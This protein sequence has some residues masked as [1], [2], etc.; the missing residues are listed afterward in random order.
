MFSHLAITTV[1]AQVEPGHEV[2]VF[3]CGSTTG[4]GP[5]SATY[6]PTLRVFGMTLGNSNSGGVFYFQRAGTLGQWVSI[7]INVPVNGTY[8]V[9]IITRNNN[10]RGSVQNYIGRNPI[11]T[12]TTSEYR[13]GNAIGSPMN[14]QAAGAPAANAA[15]RNWPLAAGTPNVVQLVAASVFLEQ[16]INT[17]QSVVTTAGDV[18]IVGLYITLIEEENASSDY[19]SL[20]PDVVELDITLNPTINVTATVEPGWSIVRWRLDDESVA[21]ISGTGSTVGITAKS[22]GRTRLFVTVTNGATEETTA[23]N[24]IVTDTPAVVVTPGSLR[25]DATTNPNATLTAAVAEGWGNIQWSSSNP[26]IASVNPV[27]GS[28]SVTVTGL[29]TGTVNIIATVSNG[30]QTSTSVTGVVVEVT[31]PIVLNRNS[32]R[33]NIKAPVPTAQVVASP[34]SGY[35]IQSWSSQESGIATVTPEANLNIAIIRA[36]APGSTTLTVTAVR[37]A[38]NDIK[39]LEFGVVVTDQ[40][41]VYI[42]YTSGNPSILAVNAVEKTIT[43]ANGTTA[44]QL[45]DAGIITAIPGAAAITNVS[46]AGKTG[47]AAVVDGDTLAVTQGSDTGVYGIVVMGDASS[48]DIRANAWVSDEYHFEFHGSNIASINH[49]DCEIVLIDG[50]TRYF[51]IAEIVSNFGSGSVDRAMSDAAN[52]TTYTGSVGRHRSLRSASNT[53]TQFESLNGTNQTYQIQT[54][55]GAV[56]TTAM[57]VTGDKLVVTAQDG[58]TKREYSIV[59][60]QAALSGKLY[61]ESG[62]STVGTTQDLILTYHAGQRTPE[63]EVVIELPPGV[64]ADYTNT[65]VNI[66]GRGEVRLDKFHLSR[67]KEIGGV[68][69]NQEM[70]KLLGRFSVNYPYQTLGTVNIDGNAATGKTITFNMLDLRPNNGED[71]ILRIEGN[72]VN[73]NYAGERNFSAR[74]KTLD[75]S[76]TPST[77]A[78]SSL[79]QAS[80]STVLN[81]VHNVSSLKREIYDDVNFAARSAIHEGYRNKTI[82]PGSNLA[83]LY[84]LRD[85]QYTEGVRAGD[86]TGF[87]MYWIPPT[88]ATSVTIQRATGT[89]S[90]SGVTLNNDWTDFATVSV[91]ADSYKITGLPA[92]VYNRFRINV[93]GGSNPGPSNEVGFYSGRLS[94]GTLGLTGTTAAAALTNTA[95]INDAI[96]WLSSIDG[97]TLRF[98]SG[99]SVRTGTIRL[100]SNV[101]LYVDS[102]AYLHSIVGA[103]DDPEPGWWCYADYASGTDAD[104]NPYRNPDN[105]MSKQDDGH[106]FYQNAM[107]TGR[108]IENYKIL[109]TGRI[110]GTGLQQGDRACSRPT[111]RDRADTLIAVKLS[112][113]FELG[114]RHFRDNYLGYDL[115]FDIENK[116]YLF[117]GQSPVPTLATGETRRNGARHSSYPIWVDRATKE[118]V[119]EGQAVAD[120]MLKIENGG[121][122]VT[123]VSADHHHIHNVYYGHNISDGGGRNGRDVF[124]VMSSNDVYVTNIMASGVSDD[125]VALKHDCALGFTRPGRSYFIRNIVGDTN[126]NNFQIGSE[127]AD[128]VQDVYIDNLVG[129]GSSKCAFSISTNDGAYMKN[130]NLNTEHTGPAI[131]PAGGTFLRARTPIFI[132]ISHRG[133]VIGANNGRVMANGTYQTGG[134][135]NSGGFQRVITNVPIGRIEDITLNNVDIFEAYSGAAY[136]SGYYPY[137]SQDFFTSLIA[138]YAMPPGTEMIRHNYTNDI[139]SGYDGSYSGMPD[140]R[141]VGFIKNMTFNDMDILMKGNYPASQRSRVPNELN[142]GGYNS[143]DIGQ[144]PSYGLFVTHT[145]GFYYNGGNIGVERTDNTYAITFNNCKNIFLKDLI[146][147]KG[148]ATG[149]TEGPLADGI[150]QFRNTGNINITNVGYREGATA[151]RRMAMPISGNANAAQIVRDKAANALRPAVFTPNLVNYGYRSEDDA[152]R[153]YSAGRSWVYP[154]NKLR[155][156][157]DNTEGKYTL[158]VENGTEKAISGY[159]IL[160]AYDSAGKLISSSMQKFEASAYHTASAVFEEVNHSGALNYKAFLWDEDFIPLTPAI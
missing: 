122:F 75:R 51:T 59:V 40:A 132:T 9:E 33:I 88:G 14:L 45:A 72:A 32:F 11:P 102:G 18:C 129:L 133:R 76:I 136:N 69:E 36:I 71:I 124:D 77:P 47:T 134:G 80:E 118:I 37:T 19:V 125:I 110:Q 152:H 144:R 10:A 150:L 63:A 35:A 97:G 146:V 149:V 93:V 56:K 158:A 43:V 7:D 142:V 78:L 84:A 159:L 112:K 99:A 127:T 6:N 92:N 57:P 46:V 98:P 2:G 95:R 28:N 90:T 86:Y 52:R 100:R 155:F 48:T 50:M 49:E 107:F 113:N 81:V 13:S 39:T 38:D 12:P 96:Q 143:P 154:Y 131:L 128:D 157:S 27:S 135:S 148:P 104:Q 23:A 82:E 85:L 119:L 130:I 65:Y 1:T 21:E 120:N 64:D 115:S 138:G 17:F 156:I 74:L 153:F 117:H 5:N 15:P 44:A 105:F 8:K 106:T 126:C 151:T 31:P 91:S 60:E 94:A 25:L 29:T 109:G 108:R 111:A 30:V 62:P 66:I 83:E 139:T 3:Y 116:V 61:V 26:S 141:L 89:Y 53:I 58:V 147:D 101:I 73:F 22:I 140:G 41:D 67:G 160:A 87:E 121:H 123:L 42:T 79:G 114:G 55:G 34:A 145:D 137:G 24:V 54:A 70:H 4:A 20:T 68:F 103:F 16:G